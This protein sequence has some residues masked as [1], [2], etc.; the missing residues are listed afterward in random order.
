[1][2]ADLFGPFRV[3]EMTLANRMVMAP[4][5]R[6]RAQA[7]GTVPSAMAVHYGQR[8]SAG[9]IVSESVPV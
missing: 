3:G 6:N 1:M 2:S 4:L 8:A 5:T 9:L 7:D